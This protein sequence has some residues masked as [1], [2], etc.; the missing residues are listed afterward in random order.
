[1]KLYA[2]KSH[3]RCLPIVALYPE[4]YIKQMHPGEQN[5]L[6]LINDAMR[7]KLTQEGK[8]FKVVER[9]P[10]ERPAEPNLF[11]KTTIDRALAYFGSIFSQ[12]K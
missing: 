2:L 6:V 7:E 3:L 1:M 10:I 5:D 11:A 12:L 9:T 8:T 4:D